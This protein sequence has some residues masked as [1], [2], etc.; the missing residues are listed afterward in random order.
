MELTG[1]LQKYM[2][3]WTCLFSS[4]LHVPEPDNSFYKLS[5]SFVS[6]R[7]WLKSLKLFRQLVFFSLKVSFSTYQFP[8]WVNTLWCNIYF[9]KL[10]SSQVLAMLN[11]IVQK[12]RKNCAANFWKNLL[13][14]SAE[15]LSKFYKQ[16]I[17]IFVKIDWQKNKGILFS[18]VK[19][20]KPVLL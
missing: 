18:I 4:K 12:R 11:I 9:E 6:G 1:Y 14:T 16:L 3:N 20:W 10:W 15:M 17:I 5:D 8:Q 2:N 19:I 13:S 7:I